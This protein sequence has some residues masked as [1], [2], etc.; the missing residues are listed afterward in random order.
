FKIANLQ[1][2]LLGQPDDAIATYN[3]ILADDDINLRAIQALDRLYQSRE[4][5]SELAENLARQLM[6]TEDMVRQVELNL[7]LGA[8]RLQKLEQPGLAVETY[9]RVLEI[10]PHND[11]ALAALE[12]L[13]ANEDHQLAV[14]R[15]LQPI[16]EASNDWPKLIHS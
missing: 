4:Q 6:L 10:E 16:Y 13:L 8:L 14:A 9:S 15:I 5:W 3:E 1:E 2:D 11:T 12:S 7:R